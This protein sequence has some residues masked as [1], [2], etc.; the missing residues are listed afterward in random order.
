MSIVMLTVALMALVLSVGATVALELKAAASSRASTSGFY[1]AEAGLNIRADSLREIFVGYNVPQGTPPNPSITPCTS[2]NMG[3]GDFVCQ[4][5]FIN[6]RRVITYVIPDSSNPRLLTIPKGELYQG[7]TA[8]EY[9]YTVVARAQNIANG[10]TEA[11][12]E[13]KLRSRLVPLFQFAAFYNKDLEI[14]PGP[15]MFLAGPVHTNG[16]LYLDSGNT[17]TINGQVTTARNLY[18]GRKNN[19]S[20]ISNSVR[21]H[22]PLNPALLVPNCPSRTQVTNSMVIGWNN[23]IQVGV[24]PLQ[25]PDPGMLNNDPSGIYWSRADLRLVLNASSNLIE[26]RDS[27]NNVIS[28][29]TQTFRNHSACQNVARRKVFHNR[30]ER[31][32]PDTVTTPPARSDSIPGREIVLLD[33]NFTNL[34]NCL[35]V[36]NWL[37]TNKRLND[38]SDG[39]LVFF[40]TVVGPGANPVDANNNGLPDEP[41]PYGVRVYNANSLRASVSNPSPVPVPK[42]VTIASDQAIYIWGNFNATNWIPAAILADS[43]NILSSGWTDGT[44]G[45]VNKDEFGLN[46]CD[47]NHAN[48]AA[49]NT[50]IQAAFLAGT[51]VT[52]FV[53]GE[54]GHNVNVYNGGLENYPRFHENWTN[55]TLTYRGSFVSLT[56]PRK[57]RGFWASQ[58]Y[59]P[60]IRDWQYDTRFNNAANLPPLTPRFVYQKQQL[61]LRHF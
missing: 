55:R 5:A 47:I 31:Q 32:I 45:T 21:I 24:Q 58:C 2:N 48:R 37:G 23:M 44:G 8:Q 59:T 11:H 29:Q 46:S 36:T 54:G 3:T 15:N 35:H 33:I 42:G 53:E 40:F 17:L 26:V 30:R 61:Y 6:N 1:A 50:T 60:P 13:L 4:E 56:T 14:L 34:L 12:L 9:A 22:D 41:S 38:T 10:S 49:S 43:I 18:R 51:D 27:S 28:T 25:V 20:C 39:G 19:S 52:G 16:N 57:V 7:L